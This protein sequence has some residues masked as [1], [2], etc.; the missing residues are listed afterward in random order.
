MAASTG[1]TPDRPATP[2]RTADDQIGLSIDSLVQ[3]AARASAEAPRTPAADI[4]EAAQKLA[5]DRIAVVLKDIETAAKA[6]RGREPAQ[7]ATPVR[8]AATPT[9]TAP[10]PVIEV[11]R[12]PRVEVYRRRPSG[13][14]ERD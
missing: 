6:A 4:A 11:Y 10:P 14:F 8:T 3:T 12:K 5:S 1:F 9:P 13:Q 2:R 7:R